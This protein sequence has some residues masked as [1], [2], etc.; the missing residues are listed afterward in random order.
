MSKFKLNLILLLFLQFLCMEGSESHSQTEAQRF[1]AEYDIH[2]KSGGKRSKAAD[3]LNAALALQP[4][5]QAYRYAELEL[6]QSS[7]FSQNWDR[8]IKNSKKQLERCKKFHADF[9]KYR[10]RDWNKKMVFNEHK[11]FGTGRFPFNEIYSRQR[12]APTEV[13]KKQLVELCN[14]LRT[15][16]RMDL[17]WNFHP[18]DLSDGLNSPI[19]VWHYGSVV[20]RSNRCRYYGDY[21]QFLRQRARAYSIF[22]DHVG[23]FVKQH[24]K[25]AAKTNKHLGFLGQL[26]DFNIYSGSIRI[27]DK[28]IIEHLLNNTK[29]IDK[30][31]SLPLANAQK[32]AIQLRLRQKLVSA[33]RTKT[34]LA[35]II[36]EYFTELYKFAPK[37]FVGQSKGLMHHDAFIGWWVRGGIQI[38]RVRYKIFRNNKNLIT[39]SEKI[40]TFCSQRDWKALL[41]YIDKMRNCNSQFIKQ[42]KV[43]NHYQNL[44]NNFGGHKVPSGSEA[45]KLFEQM[46]RDFDVRS[47]NYQK[48]FAHPFPLFVRGVLKH[49]TSIYLLMQEGHKN[50]MFLGIWNLQDQTV[51]LLL[52][53]VD[54]YKFSGV[55][56]SH[57]SRRDCA[58]WTVGNGKVVIACNNGNVAVFSLDNNQWQLIKDVIPTPPRGVAVAGNKIFVLCGTGRKKYDNFLISFGFSGKAYTIHFS[59]A[60][61]DKQHNLE[62]LTGA[63]NS[64]ITLNN[65]ELAFLISLG[66]T[67]AVYRYQLTTGSFKRICT[68]PVSSYED[69]LYFQNGKLYCLTDG[70]GSRIYRINPTDG[71][72]V[73]TMIQDNFRYKI[74][75]KDTPLLLK[76]NWDLQGPF[77]FDKEFLWSAYY[78]PAVVSWKLPKQSLQLFLPNSPFLTRGVE[79]NSVIYFSFSHCFVV[80]PKLEQSK[81][82]R[83]K[84]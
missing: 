40:R 47:Y 31:Q 12:S 46:N 72:F 25:Q 48:M 28:A 70:H 84:K 54:P 11:V 75:P 19:E 10:N 63:V 2:V 34:S 58:P 14:E 26:D 1:F 15:L 82:V 83:R 71:S 59:N 66:Y 77:V 21:A 39:S 57:M 49:K 44:A 73:C 13:Q 60:R 80:K 78:N 16:L 8:W 22:L 53:P 32:T 3:K 67:A 43:A 30:L 6:Y 56:E 42:L 55:S 4:M 51:K 79:Q 69:R 45:M 33:P 29:L 24:P 38:A 7:C 64:L 18:Y 68:L 35:P 17:K 20:W 74:N 23:K 52:T 65:N 50:K 62:K 36:D 5:N 27:N 9:P 37:T 76:T 41:S 61:D 81:K